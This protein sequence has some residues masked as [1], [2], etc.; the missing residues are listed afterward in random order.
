[1]RC[2]CI[3]KPEGEPQ[4]IVSPSFFL[5]ENFLLDSEYNRFHNIDIKSV[6]DYVQNY[7]NVVLIFIYALYCFSRQFRSDKLSIKD[8]NVK[9]AI[10]G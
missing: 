8:N 7:H 9:E 10:N 5:P 6:S 4:H 2:I 3:F 1:L